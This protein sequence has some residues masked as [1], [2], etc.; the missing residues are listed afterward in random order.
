ML[1]PGAKL[2]IMC[3]CGKENVATRNVYSL[4]VP[5]RDWV[6]VLVQIT[7]PEDA[8]VSSLQ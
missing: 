1:L 8:C 5:M 6:Q 4:P 3:N 2:V 7:K